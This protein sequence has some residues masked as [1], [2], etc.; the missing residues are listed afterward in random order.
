MTTSMLSTPLLV[1]SKIKYL[2][3]AFALFACLMTGLLLLSEY[4]FLEPYVI[5]HLPPESEFE[6][7]LI[8]AIS[9]LSALVIPMNLYRIN[10]LKNSKNKIGGGIFGSTIGIIAGA[11]GCGPAGFAIISVFGSV[12]A[13]ASVFLINYE[14]PI[15]I[16]SIGILVLMYFTTIKSLK[17]ECK[18]N[19]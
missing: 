18:V 6:F 9:A 3:I 4:I 16:L 15:Q 7:V 5:S 2:A 11:C 17:N 19:S 12:G 8:V 14:T 13:T 10:I 1:F